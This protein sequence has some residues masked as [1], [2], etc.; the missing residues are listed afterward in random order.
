M[1]RGQRR[2]GQA[3]TIQT[4]AERA[5]VSPMTVSNVI[6]GTKKMREETRQAVM[7]AIEELGY[8]PNTAARALASAR[9]TRIGVVYRNAQNAFLSAMLVGA[10][11]AAARL[12]AQVIVA[13]CGSFDFDDAAAAV[14][15]LIR[16]G[17]NAILLAPPYSETLSGTDFSAGLTV[18]VFAIA[19][20]APLPDMDSIGVNEVAAAR[21]MTEHLLERGHRR[22]G[23][24]TGPAGHASST[25]R[26]RGFRSALAAHGMEAEE[27]LVAQGDFSFDSGLAAAAALLDRDD[28]PSAIFASNDDM[29]AAVSL[30]AHRR[31]LRVPEDLAVAGFDDAPIAVKIWPPLSTIRQEIEVMAERATEMLVAR[32]REGGRPAQ[33][34]AERIDYE[35]IAR[36][37]T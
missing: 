21:D 7:A 35:V 25:S 10:L 9:Q 32:H 30:V 19:H 31:G 14:S 27:S 8:V 15:S 24:I 34:V 3:V 18:P 2:S 13:K 33:P 22:I 17:A 16:N 36:E 6:N 28:R 29:A 1:A 12:G 26:L 20:G 4:V 11:N 5:G 23:F 37:S